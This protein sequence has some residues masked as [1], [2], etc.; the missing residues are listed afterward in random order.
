MLYVV[1][2]PIGNLQ[3]ITLRAIEVLKRIDVIA[4][5][6]T[7]TSAKLL[8]HFG[9]STS[10]ISY[11]EHN[12]RSRTPGLIARMKSGTDVALISDAGTP[13]ISDPGFYLVR[14][15]HRH[16]IDVAVLPGASAALTALVASGLPC[17]RFV[18]E[19]FLPAKKGRKA[20]MEEIA[21][22]T[23]TVVLYESPHRILKTLQQLE[24]L[25][26]TNRDVAVARE[27]TKQ[28]EEVTRGSLGTVREALASREKQRGEFVVVLGGAG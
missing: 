7:R 1:P 11:H 22:E 2:T 17:D 27:L 3:D 18:F 26:G 13:G 25:C 5:E 8:S 20:R 12:E 10:R 19:G 21:R 16:G 23:R 14:E 24:E 4:C 28:F 9:I 6:D 15:C